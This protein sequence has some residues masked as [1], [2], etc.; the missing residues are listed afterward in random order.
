MHR[1][2]RFLIGQYATSY[3]HK[4]HPSPTLTVPWK[5]QPYI[6]AS[7]TLE[8]K[9]VSTH[10]RKYRRQATINRPSVVTLTKPTPVTQVREDAMDRPQRVS[11]LILLRWIQ[12][13][14]NCTMIVFLIIMDILDEASIPRHPTARPSLASLL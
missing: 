7:T 9:Q 14:V 1:T 5:A 8:Y 3:I 6:T 12:R 11:K 2:N 4:R 10:N 13:I